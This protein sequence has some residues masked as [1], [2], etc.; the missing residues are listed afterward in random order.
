MAVTA[1]ANNKGG[2]GKSTTTVNLTA[3]AALKNKVLLIDADPQGNASK[4]LGIE[5]STAFRDLM[6]GNEFEIVKNVRKNLDVIANSSAGIGIELKV[7]NEFGREY[8]E[9]Y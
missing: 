6:L 1:I 5:D 8:Q 9:R 2:V 3:Q 7:A 4:N